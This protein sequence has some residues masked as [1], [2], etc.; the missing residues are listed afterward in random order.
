MKG[1]L[2][3]SSFVLS[4]FHLEFCVFDCINRSLIELAFW[5][6]QNGKRNE[7]KGAWNQQKL[8]LLVDF[9]HLSFKYDFGFKY[10][11]ALL[12]GMSAAAS[13]FQIMRTPRVKIVDQG[14]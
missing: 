7:A 6:T 4:F 1:K 10:D 2:D 8:S 5:C 13:Y 12:Q 3:L 14:E 9:W 11:F